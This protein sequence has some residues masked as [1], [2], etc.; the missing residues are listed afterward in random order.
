ML[1][2]FRYSGNH[3]NNDIPSVR[4]R[5]SQLKRDIA[6]CKSCYQIINA[7]FIPIAYSRTL[8]N[9][10]DCFK[11]PDS[12]SYLLRSDRACHVLIAVVTDFIC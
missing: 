3:M 8:H 6:Q 7:I 11:V 10:Y 4:R 5:L 1:C 12:R 2:S 9:Y